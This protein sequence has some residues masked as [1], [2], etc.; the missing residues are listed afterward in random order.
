MIANSSVLYFMCTAKV[1]SCCFIGRELE[2]DILPMIYLT[3][4]SRAMLLPYPR[5]IV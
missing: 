5:E 2:L 1:C 4:V 3:I